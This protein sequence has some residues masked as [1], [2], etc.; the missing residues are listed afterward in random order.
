MRCMIF[1]ESII[2]DTAMSFQD[3]MD[4][5]KTALNLT[6]NTHTDA[7]SE[8]C[9]VLWIDGN[10]LSKMQTADWCLDLLSK[11]GEVQRQLGIEKKRSIH[12]VMS[13]A[14]CALSVDENLSF[15]EKLRKL[16]SDLSIAP[17]EAPVLKANVRRTTAV[18][19]TA[20]TLVIVVLSAVAGSRR[21]LAI[22]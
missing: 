9:E 1:L 21:P 3:K 15:R 7:L 17:T 13:Q 2:Q 8:G 14:C 12:E 18:R 5:I 20:S 16:C 19:T 4:Q 10:G 6:S 11:L 22:C